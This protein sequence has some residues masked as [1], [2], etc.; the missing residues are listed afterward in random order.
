[1]TAYVDRG[2]SSCI[3]NLDAVIDGQSQLQAAARGETDRG[4]H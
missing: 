4:T 3:L 1:M 2:A